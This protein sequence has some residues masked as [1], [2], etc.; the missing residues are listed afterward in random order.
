MNKFRSEDTDKYINSDWIDGSD[1]DNTVTQDMDVFSDGEVV[2]GTAAVANDDS[3]EKVATEV[4][5]L[6]L[7]SVPT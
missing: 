2:W 1:S 3:E 5:Q 6:L 7:R 4:F